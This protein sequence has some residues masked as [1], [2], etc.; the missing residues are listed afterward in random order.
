M[1]DERCVVA[2]NAER[3]GVCWM[4]NL[5]LYCYCK[6]RKAWRDEAVRLVAI[7]CDAYTS[8]LDRDLGG[9]HIDDIRR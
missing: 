6:G 4:S 7:R 5:L 9:L 2:N 8:E 3:A 1:D